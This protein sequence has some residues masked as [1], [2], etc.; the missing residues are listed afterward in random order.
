MSAFHAPRPPRAR[1]RAH[2]LADPV[3]SERRQWVPLLWIGAGLFGAFEGPLWPAMLVSTAQHSSLASVCRTLLEK[4]RTDLVLLQSL[5]S[6]E[7][8]LELRATQTALILV[9]A[10]GGIAAEQLFFSRLLATG[11]T[12]GYFVPSVIVIMAIDAAL[13]F[14]L[15]CW[16]IPN[17]GL[18]ERRK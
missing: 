16:A 12:A 8:A 18:R 5:L 9:M 1:S 17:S 13:L 6:E 4:P 2:S 7:Y 10:K 15:F 3:V 11:A 14:L